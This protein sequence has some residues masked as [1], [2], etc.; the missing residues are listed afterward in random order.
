MVKLNLFG[1][2]IQRCLNQDSFPELFELLSDV[3]PEFFALEL[4]QQICSHKE[5]GL[6]SYFIA[7]S[8]IVLQCFDLSCVVYRRHSH[9]LHQTLGFLDRRFVGIGLDLF[10]PLFFPFLFS[11]E[12]IHLLLDLLLEAGELL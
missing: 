1:V 4:S 12:C 2:N 6:F 11:L 9:L 5:P 7:H 10:F 8:D 3:I